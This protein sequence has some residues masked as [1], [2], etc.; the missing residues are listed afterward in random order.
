MVTD[1]RHAL[2]GGMAETATRTFVTP[3]LSSGIYKNVLT[4]DEKNFLEEVMGLEYNALSIYKKENNFWDSSN[5]NSV[6]KVTLGKNDNFLDLSNPQD[7]IKYKILL[8]NKDSIAKSMQDLEDHPKATYQYVIISQGDEVKNAGIKMSAK[9]Q[10]Y[11]ELGK[12]N[13]DADTLRYIIEVIERKPLASSSK[14][15]FLEAKADEL[16]TADSKN[17]LRV[18]TDPML[19][20]KVLLKKAIE[21]ALLG[22]RGDYYYLKDGTPLCEMNEEP[23]FNVAAKY[24]D[25]PKHQD[26]KLTLQAQLNKDD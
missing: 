14:I 3:V 11:K 5:D 18:I 8:A 15:E 26:I 16:I 24:L 20:T 12:I 10:C 9:K 23:T 1:P 7:Y 13:D 4:D 25:S 19:Q 21:N 2:Y 6:S 17:F 22:R